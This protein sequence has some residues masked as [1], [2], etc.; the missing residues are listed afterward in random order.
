[1]SEEIVIVLLAMLVCVLVLAIIILISPVWTWKRFRKQAGVK[2]DEEILI[3]P[4]GADCD[5][6][7]CRHPPASPAPAAA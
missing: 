2:D 3:M 7:Y 4:V 6:A 5:C 1:M